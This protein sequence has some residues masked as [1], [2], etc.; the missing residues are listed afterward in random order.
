[1]RLRTRHLSQ[2]APTSGALA[3]LAA[4]R[5]DVRLDAFARAIGASYTRYADDVAL[6]GSTELARNASS[7][8]ARIAA[9]AHDEGFAIN[10]RKTRVMVR[11]GRQRVAG[12]VVNDKLA[13]SRVEVDRLRAILHN[14]IR[15][16]PSTQNRENHADF[17]AHLLGRI[18]W[19]ASLDAAKGQKL[20]ARFAQIPW[21]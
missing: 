3:N 21:T 10:F 8:V 7:A 12:V 15:S 13:V 4:Y 5:F 16:G 9:I 17:R 6:S 14:C 2:G 18:S 11:A 20:M 1:M 19:V